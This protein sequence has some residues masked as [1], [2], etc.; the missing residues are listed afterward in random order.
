[1]SQT[2]LALNE[3]MNKE[4]TNEKREIVS[5]DMLKKVCLSFVF[6][7]LALSINYKLGAV[8]L[9][10]LL[11]SMLQLYKKL[12]YYSMIAIS[13]V[14]LLIDLELSLSVIS[15]LVPL[16]L[17]IHKE[18]K[19]ALNFFILT[20]V[21]LMSYCINTIFNFIELNIIYCVFIILFN[22]IFFTIYDK[23][24]EINQHK[25]DFFFKEEIIGVLTIALNLSLGLF[26]FSL[27]FLNIGFIFT[28]LLIMLLGLTTSKANTVGYSLIIYFILSYSKLNITGIEIIPF[29][30]LIS[31]LLPH[32]N[33]YLKTFTFYIISPL[34][35]YFGYLSGDILYLFISVAVSTTIFYI[36]SFY[37]NHKFANLLIPKYEESKYY[38]IYVENFREDVSQRLL[39]F[40]ELFNAFANKSL[41][42]NN[43]LV[44]IDEAI[45]EMIDKHCKNCLKKELC[46]NTNHIK[47]YNY[48][49]QLL[50]EGEN[51]LST[52]KKRFLD[53]FGMFCLNAFDII[54]TAIELNQEYLL[55]NIK[56]SNSN[57]VF[58]SQ[59]EG[60]SRILQDYAIEVNTDY[61]SETI[62][63]EKMRDKMNKLGMNISYLKVNSIKKKNVD[64]DLGIK[65]YEERYDHVI[66]NLINDLLKEEVELVTT[67]KGKS[68]E[69]IKIISKQIFDLEF[70]TSYI[71][72]DGSRISGDNFLKSDMHNGNTV[73]ALS[74][75]MGNGYSAYIESKSTLE[76]LNKML[77]TGADDHTAV[78]IINTLLSLKEYNERFSTLDYIT[79][80]KS[81]GTID[82][83][84]IGSAPSFIIRGNKVICINNDNLPMGISKEV[85]KIT[86]DLEPNDIVVVVS[87]GVVERFNNIN[88]FEK[89]I[90]QMIRT[91]SIQMA[92][93]IIRAA[94]TEFGGKI[95]DDM[96]AIVIKVN[97]SKN[98][99]SA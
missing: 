7:I 13:S 27:E 5:K 70:G 88:K 61:E 71:G 53:L 91:S 42:T 98:K 52:D 29:L 34:M 54:N 17:L 51:I 32:N 85:D 20:L 95:I 30:G 41:E 47:T 38:Q 84:K 35:Y 46:L 3:K 63:I 93:D 44:K 92:H 66:C 16:S 60:L 12:A 14:S 57:M 86:F 18:N 24:I 87:D 56:Q 64:I 36:T 75:G 99:I 59:L 72:K 9:L 77:T 31:A 82:F 80:N 78:S 90:A 49:N 67:K 94:I 69:K 6:S 28:L 97:P 2:L 83:Y 19:K 79:I 62:K 40:A 26:T 65:D 89:I 74:D 23:A 76:L 8:F 81:S 1:M 21:S 15:A 25:K 68:T 73:I 48:F 50:K 37:F 4:M 45:D 58:Q 10:P 96:T 22:F 39:N 11:C 33:I 43:E 55:G